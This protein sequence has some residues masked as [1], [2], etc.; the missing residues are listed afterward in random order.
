MNTNT[1]EYEHEQYEYEYE[2]EGGLQGART[3]NSINWRNVNKHVWGHL[4]E[5][6]CTFVFVL[7]TLRSRCDN[8]RITRLI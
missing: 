3:N 2:Y 5:H 4:L 6:V 1:N 7:A 8:D